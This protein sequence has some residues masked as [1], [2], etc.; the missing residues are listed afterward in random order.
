MTQA[1]R[2]SITVKQEGVIEIHNPALSVGTRAEV[3]VLVEPPVSEDRPLA[4]YL[5]RG[6]GCFADAN[7]VDSFLRAERESWER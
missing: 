4:S 1:I 7:E 5:G 3:I 6:Q 2:E